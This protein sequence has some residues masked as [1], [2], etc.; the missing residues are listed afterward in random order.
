MKVTDHCR[1]QV[2]W[3]VRLKLNWVAAWPENW[4]HSH[5]RGDRAYSA[6]A[7]DSLTTLAHLTI[8]VC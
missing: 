7:P 5:D 3:P 6:L 4:M 1:C 8:S 2:Q